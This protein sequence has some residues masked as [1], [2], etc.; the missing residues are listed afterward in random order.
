MAFARAGGL[1][2]GEEVEDLLER[3][4]RRPGDGALGGKAGVGDRSAVEAAERLEG[5][6]ADREARRNAAAAGGAAE[7]RGERRVVRQDEDVVGAD[8]D[9][10]L[11]AVGA[12]REGVPHRR[13]RVL[14]EAGARAAVPD[15]ERAGR[16]GSGRRR[17]PG[18]EDEERNRHPRPF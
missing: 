15:D 16:R 5:E 13:Q 14:R 3:R 8:A 7:V 2:G 10:D 4:D 1:G 6:P 17:D 11:D 18:E 9:V 12:G